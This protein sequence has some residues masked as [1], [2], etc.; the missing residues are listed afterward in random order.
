MKKMQ[1][2]A[3]VFAMGLALTSCGGNDSQA[4]A[5]AAKPAAPA[6][7]AT[8]SAAIPQNI[9][10]RYVDEEKLLEEYNLAKDF[11]ESITRLQSKL[12]SAQQSRANDIQ[13]LGQQIENKMKNNGYKTEQEYNADM[14]RI[15]K[16]QSDAESY[17][18]NL[19]R[20]TEVEV[21]ALQSQLQDSIKGF[22]KGFAQEHGYDAVLMQS[23][24]FYF[25]PALDV[26]EQVVEGLNARY[27]KVQK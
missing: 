13:Q 12:I 9:S 20:T 4:S 2:F 21:A 16:K 7:S 17:L 26:T 23:V 18:S 27:N 6:D 24:G 3:A 8:T 1:C 14:A 25:N 5:D 11:Q 10:L 19:Q 15:Q 22:I